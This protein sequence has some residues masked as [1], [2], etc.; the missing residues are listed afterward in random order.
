[1]NWMLFLTVSQCLISMFD[2][3]YCPPGCPYAIFTVFF[4][5]IVRFHLKSFYIFVL[6]AQFLFFRIFYHFQAHFCFLLNYLFGLNQKYFLQ[7]YQFIL[8]NL[9]V[10]YFMIRK[11]YYFSLAFYSFILFLMWAINFIF[12]LSL[13]LS[14]T[15]NSTIAISDFNFKWIWFLQY[16]NYY[17]F[18]EWT[19]QRSLQYNRA[20]HFFLHLVILAILS[21]FSL[22]KKC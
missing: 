9:I 14:L 3:K 8:L 22:I 11:C 20:E 5:L 1:M 12:T 4:L 7:C 10:Q 21:I 2:L 15:L 18:D 16:N 19:C 17:L 13:N 6:F